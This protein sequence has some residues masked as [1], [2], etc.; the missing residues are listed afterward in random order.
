MS[1]PFIANRPSDWRI[2]TTSGGSAALTAIIVSGGLTAGRLY[3][4]KNS[5]AVASSPGVVVLS[6]AGAGLGISLGPSPVDLGASD[7]EM[8]SGGA[9]LP[10]SAQ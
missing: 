4:S 5:K 7:P 1:E 3:I 8:P 9:Y 6:Y 2:V 10:W